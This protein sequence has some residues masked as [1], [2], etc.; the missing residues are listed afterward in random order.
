MAEYGEVLGLYD[1]GKEEMK[2]ELVKYYGNPRMEKV[3]NNDMRYSKYMCKTNCLLTNECRYL[4]CFV[5]EDGEKEG[6]VRELSG[7]SW[8]C[9]QTRTLGR[10][11]VVSHMYEPTRNTKL[12]STISRIQNTKE[13]SVYE[14]EAYPIQ[15]TLMGDGKNGV[16]YLDRGTIVMALETFDTILV[17]VK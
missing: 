8:V 13:S 11:N 10:L 3:R 1:P 5:E 9:F 7:L 17:F 12:W 15:V 6:T 4:L 2:R 14:S 16:S